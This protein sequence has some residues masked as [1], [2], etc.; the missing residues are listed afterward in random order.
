MNIKSHIHS[1]NNEIDVR[2]PVL[3]W[4]TVLPEQIDSCNLIQAKK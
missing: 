4:I 3:E 2:I 1:T